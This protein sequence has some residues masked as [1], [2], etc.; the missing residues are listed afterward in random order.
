MEFLGLKE[1][2]MSYK[3]YMQAKTHEGDTYSQTDIGR[4][5]DEKYP[6]T[7]THNFLRR[8]IVDGVLTK[9]KCKSISYK[10]KTIDIYIIDSD[11]LLEIL[12]NTKEFKMVREIIYE[13]IMFAVN[14]P[15]VKTP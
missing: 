15:G 3:L 8:L 5:I 13:D 2:E 6:N 10:G 11:K 12:K 14:K 4:L 9:D 7:Q 1:I